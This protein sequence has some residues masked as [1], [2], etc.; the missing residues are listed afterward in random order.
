MDPQA[1]TPRETERSTSM[2][3]ELR[4][5]LVGGLILGSV[6]E[7]YS[8]FSVADPLTKESASFLGLLL[9][10]IT[11][12]VFVTRAGAG[13]LA[14]T[15][16]VIA[17][18]SVV[19]A[20]TARLCG[21][22]PIG[23]NRTLIDPENNAYHTF[24]KIFDAFAP[25][26][27]VLGFFALILRINDRHHA[28]IRQTAEMRAIQAEKDALHHRMQQSEKLESLGVL[29]GGVAHD[30]NNYLMGIL[31]FTEIALHDTPEESKTHEALQ[32]IH[33]VTEKATSVTRQMLAFG[34]TEAV[35]RKPIS[36]NDLA[37]GMAG[38]LQVTT[39]GHVSFESKF[40]DSPLVIDGDQSQIHQI[41]V[42]LVNN[43]A[44]ATDGR[45]PVRVT[46][47][48]IELS[49]AELKSFVLGDHCVAGEFACIS[50]TDSGAGI[51]SDILD[52]IFD[53][54]FTTKRTGRGL[55]LAVVMGSVRSH[56]GAIAV[57]DMPGGGTRFRVIF[58]L[59]T[60][61]VVQQKVVE[62]T[63]SSAKYEGTILVVDDEPHVRD[64][65]RAMCEHL[66]YTVV[67]ANDGEEALEAL[68]KFENDCTLALIDIVMPRMN[69][70]VTL[71]E[72]RRLGISIPV[73][74]MTGFSGNTAVDQDDLDDDVEILR[75]PFGVVALETAISGSNGNDVDPS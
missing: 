17:A 52:R 3:H 72:I 74:L 7:G 4:T 12:I 22:I 23:A 54:F 8:H 51:D 46:T 9:M 19:A 24:V 43:G 5:V 75:K 41:I 36:L 69:G 18:A 15:C 10:A 61:P 32:H 65:T 45:G 48:L 33:E 68:G 27:L 34:G 53:P 39:P 49:A 25:A 62:P 1:D 31:G 73:V 21:E 42:N 6:L 67:T 16:M 38:L 57:E 50:V 66:G 71:R 55:G 20:Q 35:K 64:A 63:A 40:T 29:T 58:P 59:S 26:A 11:V 60:N 13:R 70:I 44:D 37:A 30:F 14:V 56:G 28:L 47:N 2:P